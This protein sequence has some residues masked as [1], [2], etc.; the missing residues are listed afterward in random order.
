MSAHI[1]A[2]FQGKICFYF[3]QRKTE[4]LTYRKTERRKDRKTERQKD[5]KTERQK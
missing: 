2:D 4:S 5:R 3:N 1:S